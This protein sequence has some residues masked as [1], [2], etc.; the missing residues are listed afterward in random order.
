MPTIPLIMTAG[1]SRYRATFILQG[2]L[3]AQCAH[4][5]SLYIKDIQFLRVYVIILLIVTTLKSAQL[6]SLPE[7][8]LRWPGRGSRSTSQSSSR[9]IC[10]SARIQPTF[11]LKRS[12]Q[13]LPQTAGMLGAVV[14]LTFQSAAPAALCALINLVCS[15]AGNISAD[16]NGWTMARSSRTASCRSW[17]PARAKL[18]CERADDEQRRGAERIGRR[19]TNNVELGALSGT[20]GV[21]R[22]IQVRTQV[23]TIQRGDGVFS[24]SPL[25]DVMTGSELEAE[26]N[27]TGKE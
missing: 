26:W 20:R 2:V 11:L 14:K 9:A 3:F 27:S 16:A 24:K 5:I 7:A 21:L 1:I 8:I 19:R 25:D 4:Y 22:A 15:Q 6:L 12:K 18:E 23:Q 10:S 13:V 17:H